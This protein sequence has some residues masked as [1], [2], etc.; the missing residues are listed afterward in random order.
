MEV[1]NAEIMAPLFWLLEETDGIPQMAKYHP[2]GSVFNHSL[3]T[4]ARAFRETQD[5]DL[6]LAAM[7][8]DVG[9]VSGRYGHPDIAV[10]LLDCHCSPKTLWL[11]KH[12]MRAQCFISG[13]MH[14][15]AK[16]KELADNLWFRDLMQ[17]VRFDKMGREPNK[18]I[19]YNQESI[20]NKLNL[21]A[22]KKFSTLNR[23]QQRD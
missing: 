12:H 19:F 11:I 23:R 20:I 1:F 17:L 5:T 9:K 22:S 2:E 16:V 8:H 7:L 18:K 14:K 10:K 21:C 3:Q 15:L 13:E 4:M 6:I